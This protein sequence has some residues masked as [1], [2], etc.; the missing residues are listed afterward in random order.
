[1][2]Y[3]VTDRNNKD[4]ETPIVDSFDTR[5]AAEKFVEDCRNDE[6]MPQE[7]E[8]EEWEREEDA[9]FEQEND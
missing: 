2:K 7:L 1:M 9:W 5:E 4:R 8:V 3:L 6:I